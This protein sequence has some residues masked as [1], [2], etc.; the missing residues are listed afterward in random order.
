MHTAWNFVGEYLN[1][2]QG[3][4]QIGNIFCITKLEKNFYMIWIVILRYLFVFVTGKY[5]P[6]IMI[7]R[8]GIEL[9]LEIKKTIVLNSMTRWISCG[10]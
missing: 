10:I 7:I 2:K 9:G 3:R 6:E 1:I 8:P 4:R 5:L